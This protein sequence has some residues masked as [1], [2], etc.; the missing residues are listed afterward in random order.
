LWESNL[1][2]TGITPELD[3]YDEAWP[4]WTHQE[5]VPPAKFVFD[6]DGRRGIA[7]DSMIAGGCIV[8]GSKVHHSLL[9]PR[10]RVH[11]YCEIND[12][13]VFPNVEI[14]RH[15]KIR[16]ALIDRYCKIP[17]GTVIGYDAAEDKKR[18]HVSPKGVVLV[19][20]DMLGQDEV[21]G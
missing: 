2:L 3:L 8:S 6:D 21:Y 12:S 4:I 20:P 14:G 1:E 7:I 16:K 17:E 13:V 15:C 9:F 10:V 19:T 5:Q 11:S 18:F